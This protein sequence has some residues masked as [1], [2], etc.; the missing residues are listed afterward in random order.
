MAKYS[1]DRFELGASRVPALVLGETKFTTNERERLKTCLLYT[2]DA[3][4]D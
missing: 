1:D 3:A 4:D 2:S